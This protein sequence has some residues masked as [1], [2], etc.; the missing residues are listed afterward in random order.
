MQKT[1]LLLY[2]GKLHYEG[3]SVE[4]NRRTR[5]PCKYKRRAGKPQELVDA[6]VEGC[7]ASLRLQRRGIKIRTP[8]SGGKER[9]TGEEDLIVQQ[10]ASALCGMAWC[11]DDCE[12]YGSSLQCHAI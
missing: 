1:H 4:R 11:V 6:L 9:V 8:H 10:I 7:C 5:M 3:N 12:V 2:L